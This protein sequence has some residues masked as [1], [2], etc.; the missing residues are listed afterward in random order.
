MNQYVTVG[1]VTYQYDADGNLI[2]QGAT[3]YTYNDEN[4]VITVSDGTNLWKYTYDALG[5]RIAATENGV[6]SRFVIDPIGLGNVVGQ[7]NSAGNLIAHYDH[8]FGLLSRTDANSGTAYYTFY[9]IGN[10]S[11]LTSARGAVTNRYA[12]DPFGVSISQ[13]TT[14]LNPF[15]F[16]GE[17][18]VTT[19]GTGLAAM[20]QRF[21]LADLGR[22][23][24]EDPIEMWASATNLYCYVGNQPVSYVDPSGLQ[25]KSVWH[26]DILPPEVVVA[27]FIAFGGDKAGSIDVIYGNWGGGAWS[28]GRVIE[29]RDIGPLETG[30]TDW[31]DELFKIHDL[32]VYIREPGA[33]AIV[34]SLALAELL[35][36]TALRTEPFNPAAWIVFALV[37][38]EKH[39]L[40]SDW[41]ARAW[42]K[43]IAAGR[44]QLVTSISPEDKWG[45]AGYDAEGTAVGSERRFVPSGQEFEYRIE[46]WN[47]PDAPVPTQDA[48]IYDVLDPDLFD[49]STFE[50]TRVG[51]LKW[52][53]PLPGG[54]TIQTRIDC[55]PEMNIAVDITGTFDPTTGRIDWW[56][57]TVDPLTGDYPADPYAGF[58]PPFNPVTGY[59]IGWMEYRV[60]PK[61]GLASGTQIPN[62]AFVQFDFLGP[63]GP[64]PK[65][66]PW[67]NT[68]DAGIPTDASRVKALPP[69]TSTTNFLVEWSGADEANGSGIAS[70]DVYYL[71]DEGDFSL[72]LDDTT[73]TSATFTGELGHKYAFYSV[74]TDNVGHVET[75]SPIVEA[76]TVVESTS[77][78]NPRHPC[79]VTGD[80]FIAPIDVLVLIND[81]N[82]HGSR[83]LTS[84]LTPPPPPFLDPSGDGWI[85]PLDV[86]IVI[87]DINAHG[88][89]PIPSEPGGEGEYDSLV[90]RDAQAIPVSSPVVGFASDVGGSVAASTWPS[91]GQQAMWPESPP[92]SSR[93]VSKV[94][95]PRTVQDPLLDHGL[96]TSE[97]EEAISAISGE[98][99]QAWNSG[100]RA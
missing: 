81:I 34:K 76:E 67:I 18:G 91:S 73:E 51:F 44:T 48:T 90:D 4:R 3:S 65:A 57:H 22:F 56:F 23:T 66:A 82:A 31:A 20:R 72:W 84:P 61:A 14:A 19:E 93:T 47:K 50:F 25:R 8:G 38:W 98:V 11:E 13:S 71:L 17:Y 58:L 39:R 36:R 68:I 100:P 10:T 53:Q 5:N 29:E 6:T 55:R 74:A 40:L 54:Q 45:P 12:Y 52:D 15:Q 27:G 88:S 86:L 42:A 63:W 35:S 94:T 83:R 70:Y 69:V 37:Q 95:R 33:T 75:K 97:L 64:A 96:E 89:R 62:Q 43:K 7:Y 49:V 77:W 41:L 32:G 87:N 26:V 92:R 21:L 28:G 80:D 60:Q 78:Q 30:C 99:Q 59:E 2:Q 16:S 9:A 79:D 24:A 1:G 85:T 46:M